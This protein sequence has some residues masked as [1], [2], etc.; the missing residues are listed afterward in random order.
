VRVKV[1]VEVIVNDGV[2]VAVMVEVEVGEEVRV[3][4]AV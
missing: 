2:A 1:A 3:F 4:V